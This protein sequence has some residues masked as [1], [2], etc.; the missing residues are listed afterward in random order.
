MSNQGIEP[1]T[2]YFSAQYSTT[3]PL[4]L[5]FDSKLHILFNFEI[6]FILLSSFQKAKALKTN[7][8][9]LGYIIRYFIRLRK[10]QVFIQSTVHSVEKLN[11]SFCKSRIIHLTVKLIYKR[12]W[13]G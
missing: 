6:I 8:Q 5:Y 4:Q 10:K 2:L 13:L 3:R 9:T 12:V 11:C 1:G 7:I